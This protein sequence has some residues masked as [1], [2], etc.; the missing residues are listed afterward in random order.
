MQVHRRKRVRRASSSQRTAAQGGQFPPQ[1]PQRRRRSR[2]SSSGRPPRYRASHARSCTPLRLLA[3][4]LSPCRVHHIDPRLARVLQSDVRST[5]SVSSRLGPCRELSTALQSSRAEADRLRSDNEV[6][7]PAFTPLSS[8]SRP[9]CIRC[10]CWV[11]QLQSAC[12]QKSADPPGSMPT[13]AG[14]LH[15]ANPPLQLWCARSPGFKGLCEI[16]ASVPRSCCGIRLCS[17]PWTSLLTPRRRSRPAASAKPS[18]RPAPA[19]RPAATASSRRRSRRRSRCGDGGVWT[20]GVGGKIVSKG[21]AATE[22]SSCG[23]GDHPP[24]DSLTEEPL[25]DMSSERETWLCQEIAHQL[26]QWTSDI[27]W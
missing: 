16:F 19:L 20:R 5:V 21:T 2:R 8:G 6:R 18:R 7:C 27:I 13:L 12:T 9:R 25:N 22:P 17:A 3:S 4:A 14:S 1:T 24:H 23:D 26:C 10:T 15:P 11:T